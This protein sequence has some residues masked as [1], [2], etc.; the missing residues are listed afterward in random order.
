MAKATKMAEL[1]KEH[2]SD[3]EVKLVASAGGAFE[4]YL[5]GSIIFSKLDERRFPTDEEI[6]T[7]IRKHGEKRSNIDAMRNN[8][9]F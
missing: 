1:I 3:I 8:F 2:F 6:L 5:E 7:I 4:I 9:R